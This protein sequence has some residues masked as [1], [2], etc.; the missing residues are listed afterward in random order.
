MWLET[1]VFYLCV[2]G[3]QDN[4]LCFVIPSEDSADSHTHGYDLLQQKDTKPNQQ[5]EKVQGTK[6]GGKQAQAFK[7]LLPIEPHT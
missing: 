5:R 3:P 4:N 7:G 2:G 6:S 1:N